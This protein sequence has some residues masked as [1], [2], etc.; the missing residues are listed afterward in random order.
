MTSARPTILVTGATGAQGGATCAALQAR[1]F[2]VRALVRDP[3]A[4]RAR[5]LA[6]GG[7]SLALGDLNDPASLR[8]ATEGAYGVFSVQRPRG[9][10][11]D[12]EKTQGR[13]LVDAACAS[14][15]THFVHTSV[16]RTGQHAQF[17][18]WDSGVWNRDYWLDKLAV[19]DM[20]REAG[21]SR[22]TILQPAFLM[23]NYALPKATFMFPQLA[24]GRLVTAMAPQTRLQH[25]ASSDVGA[26]A[27]AALEQPERFHGR[28]IGLAA[29]DL[30]M[31]EVAAT[32]SAVT[33][34]P[35]VAEHLTPE[36]AVAAGCNPGLVRSQEWTNE[37][38]YGVDI[39]ALREWGIPLV[40]LAE[41]ARRHAG[42]VPG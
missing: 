17:P 8:R 26:F 25:I 39:A 42:D 32:L 19:E 29:E 37:V 15:V 36:A 13:A 12:S 34:R 27:C 1:G 24:A 10:R 3:Q 5:A 40:T 9:G 33:K 31:T 21:F 4:P 7:V 23:E 41:W 16:A 11:N 20:V 6:A 18:R 14:G 2:P 35:I 22:W 28:A 38:S 30:T